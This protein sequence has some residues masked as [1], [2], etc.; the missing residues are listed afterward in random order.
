MSDPILTFY[1]DKFEEYDND[2]DCFQS[3]VCAEEWMNEYNFLSDKINEKSASL[4]V[5]FFFLI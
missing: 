5:N 1:L 4:E 3:E 2:Q